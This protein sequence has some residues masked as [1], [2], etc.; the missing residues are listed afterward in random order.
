MRVSS[1][2]DPSEQSS[3]GMTCLGIGTG[4]LETPFPI[5]SLVKPGY[6]ADVLWGVVHNHRGRLVSTGWRRW[7]W[8]AEDA[9]WPRKSSSKLITANSDVAGRVGF[10]AAPV[11]MAA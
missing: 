11:R 6:P 9:R 1:S 2:R 10:T 5:A 8:H 3:F 4:R 7:W